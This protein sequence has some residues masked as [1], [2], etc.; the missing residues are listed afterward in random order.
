MGAAPVPAAV[1]EAGAQQLERLRLEN[2]TLSAVVSVVSS[3][4]DLEH[5][6]ERVVDLL[7]RAT[8]CHACFVY[9]LRGEQL[10]LLAA[11]P[12][13]GHLVGRISFGVD[14]GLAGWSV[15]HHRPAFIR[16]AAMQDPRTNYIAELEEE[17]FQ[18]MVAVPIPSRSQV[19]IGAIV[20]HTVA[21]R[22]FDEGILNVLSRAASLVAGA[23]ENAQLYQDAKLRVEALTAWS[24]LAQGLAAA[25][26]RSEL[27]RLATAGARELLP[28]DVCRLYE[29]DSDD[30]LRLVAANPPADEGGTT[31]GANARVVLDLLTSP[32]SPPSRLVALGDALGL[33]APP[34]AALALPV[35]AGD[36][37]RGVLV[38]AAREPWG[39][40]GATLMG[41]LGHLL[42]VAL[43]KADLIERLMEENVARDL[44]DALDSADLPRALGRARAAGLD[45]ERSH[46][47][48]QA[49]PLGAAPATDWEVAGPR[50]ESA[51]R[52]AIPGAVCDR[53][54]DGLR[55][56]VPTTGEGSAP[57]RALVPLLHSIAEQYRLAIGASDGRRGTEGAVRSMSEAA[58]AARLAQAMNARPVTLLY[59]DAGAYRYLTHHIDGGAPRDHLH[60]AVDIIVAYDRRRQGQLLATLERYLAAG[61]AYAPT[62]RALG[63]HVNTLRQRLERI[64]ALTGLALEDE[65]LLALQLAIKLAPLRH[66]SS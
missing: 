59:R 17:R 2:E 36:E 53:G 54:A 19:P 28:C 12:V 50:A 21:P 11:S 35:A 64:E 29:L 39:E 52:R 63:I 32:S 24:S 49:R 22:E 37:Q 15:R 27:Y 55:A 47:A 7:T 46:A 8:Q 23:I 65:D 45:L 58:D 25:T 20:L 33:D 31:G 48:V 10:R 6:L 4:P 62:A 60:D 18:S 40:H 56:L 44:F 38:V 13:Y 26:D 42:A 3:S 61:R 51:L 9:L 16:D 34:A 30:R 41:A 43:E 57:T 66:E 14:E 1:L 5:V